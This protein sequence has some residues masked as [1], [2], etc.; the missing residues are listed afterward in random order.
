MAPPSVNMIRTTFKSI[1][2]SW[3]EPWSYAPISHYVLRILNLDGTTVVDM[4]TTQA[5]A[6][7]EHTFD[8]LE[9]N[10]VHFLRVSAVSEA[11]EG[12]FIQVQVSTVQ[13]N[14]KLLLIV[15]LL[16]MICAVCY[17]ILHTCTYVQYM[18]EMQF[19]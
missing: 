5:S 6:V 8:N 15:C 13:S 3:G 18:H 19:V 16:M 12:P 2:F 1:S 9:E 14:R 17:H 10:T 11:A 7:R 4:T